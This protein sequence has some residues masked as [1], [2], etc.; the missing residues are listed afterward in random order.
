MKIV[1]ALESSDGRQSCSPRR[2]DIRPIA[3]DWSRPGRIG[4]AVSASC[5]AP[6]HPLRR[7]NWHRCRQAENLLLCEGT[8]I[9]RRRA[10]VTAKLAIEG[11]QI[12]ETGI[13]GESADRAVMMA[14][15]CEQT[16]DQREALVQHESRQRD[17]LT[18]EQLP[19][20][21]RCYSVALRQSAAGYS[22]ASKVFCDIG[23][24]SAQPRYAEPAAL[25]DISGIARCADG[26]GAEIM[27]VCRGGMPQ[28]RCRQAVLVV[29]NVEISRQEAQNAG[30]WW[31][32]ACKRI[33]DAGNHCHHLKSNLR[34]LT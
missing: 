17:A 11:R 31:K 22:A 14:R 4:H 33:L 12:S 18:F 8:H 24:Q 21:S 16:M 6:Y 30:I 34:L 32:G 5:Y 15:V 20:V 26:Q 13:K 3:A 19:D 2:S 23:L 10:V 29:D 28:L 25:G 1:A 27:D 9:R 7:S